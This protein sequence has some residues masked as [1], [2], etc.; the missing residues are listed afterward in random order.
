VIA[1]H[2]IRR[3]PSDLAPLIEQAIDAGC[4]VKVFAYDSK[5]HS[6]EDS[7]RDLADAIETWSETQPSADL[8]IDAHSMGGRVALGAL[9]RL[10]AMGTLKRHI[11]LNLIAVPL[12]GVRSA[13]FAR[14]LPRFLPF[15]RPLVGVAPSSAYQ[16]MI[17]HLQL[18]GNVDVNVFVGDRDSV[19]RHAT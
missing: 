9:A 17:E 4:T 12:A 18:P 2:G 6:L 15:V 8:R 1:V 3:T 5:F 16:Q 7:S 13:N 14:L 10:L 19:I 11:E